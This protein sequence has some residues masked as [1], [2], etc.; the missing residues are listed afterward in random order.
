MYKSWI[1]TLFAVP[2]GLVLSITSLISCLMIEIL[3]TNVYLYEHKQL[4]DDWN[5]Q[6]Y[7][8]I[9]IESTDNGC[10]LDY[11]PLFQRQW[12]GTHDYCQD[13]QGNI[14]VIEDSS[15]DCQEGF[16]IR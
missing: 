2:V 5:T 10:P 16:E 11:E 7:V 13:R 3:P 14:D 12:N 9:I 1:C 15:Q 4:Y 8:D 6:Y